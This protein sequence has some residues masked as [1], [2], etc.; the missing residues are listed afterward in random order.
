MAAHK[1]APNYLM[2]LSFLEASFFPVPPDVMLAPMTMAKP[3]NAWRYAL[4]T[5][6][7][8]VLGGLFGYFL[9]AF[10][11]EPLMEPFIIWMG[12]GHLYHTVLNWVNAYGFWI[13]FVASFTPIPYKIF[14]ITAG[15]A[16]MM[17]A[18]FLL[19]AII[20]R[21]A[22][23]FLVSSLI[24]WGGKRVEPYVIRYLDRVGWTIVLAIFVFLIY[25][26]LF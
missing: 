8:S 24:R 7:A 3:E 22:R 17:L 11:F 16:H 20:G 6:C 5:T 19:A 12:Y 23:F 10:A 15:A 14:T 9:G 4:I 25:A 26:K 18:P 21:G 2:G 1:Q 13:M